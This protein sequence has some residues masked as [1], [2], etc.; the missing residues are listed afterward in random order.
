[1]Q[2]NVPQTSVASALSPKPIRTKI[3]FNGAML[4]KQKA[5]QEKIRLENEQ[6]KAEARKALISSTDTIF[7]LNGAPLTPMDLLRLIEEVH[8][9]EREKPNPEKRLWKG[10]TL[11]SGVSGA[12]VG[13]GLIP[14]H[15]CPIIISGIGLLFGI[16]NSWETNR[17]ASTVS[18]FK[19]AKLSE[20]ARNCEIELESVADKMRS[21][22]FPMVSAGFL[23]MEGYSVKLLPL[24]HQALQDAQAQPAQEEDAIATK[25]R[26]LL[27]QVQHAPLSLAP[28]G[29]EDTLLTDLKSRQ[30]SGQ[31]ERS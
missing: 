24:G 28:E 17:K 20:N 27:E 22:L 23:D 16:C 26:H 13:L 15:P 10:L 21:A 19:V 11:A 25:A 6:K 1:M 2:L 8:Q 5:L 31:S 30:A 7:T 9:V 29:L 4:E 14:L 18:I 12:L 3:H